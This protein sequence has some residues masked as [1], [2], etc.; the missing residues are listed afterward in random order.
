VVNIEYKILKSESPLQFRLTFPEEHDTDCLRIIVH[1]IQSLVLHLN[2]V[3]KDILY[4]SADVLCLY[5]TW[6]PQSYNF[7]IDGYSILKR[8]DNSPANK[9]QGMIIYIKNYLFNENKAI[10]ICSNSHF[11][12]NNY[13]LIECLLISNT[14]LI[15]IY[16]SPKSNLN[17]L[18]KMI[19]DIYNN[20]S[21]NYN[22]IDFDLVFSGDFNIDFNDQEASGVNTIITYFNSKYIK[23]ISP[24]KSSTNFNT[25]I[26]VVFSNNINLE[27]DYFENVFSYHKVIW[28]LIGSKTTFEK[29]NITKNNNE[30]H[31]YLIFQKNLNSLDKSMNRVNICLIF[32]KNYQNLIYIQKCS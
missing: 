2:V 20:I 31:I 18:L 19:N 28:I 32:L 16:K 23:F 22:L 11:L 10:L 26:D 13:I 12:N 30:I 15:I 24:L 6:S 9:A 29:V 21:A 25:Q 4:Q 17:E 7:N 14:F 1:N 27:T 3:K 8:I 5:E